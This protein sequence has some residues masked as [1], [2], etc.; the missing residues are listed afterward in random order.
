IPPGATPPDPSMPWVPA[1][2]P[3][4]GVPAGGGSMA[5]VQ[6]TVPVQDTSLLLTGW[7]LLLSAVGVLAIRPR[8]VGKHSA[9]RVKGS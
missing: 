8:R 6:H 2:P 9:R 7:V 1:G 4:G 5:A 3:V